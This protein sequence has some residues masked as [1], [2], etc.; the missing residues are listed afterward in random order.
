[1]SSNADYYVTFSFV[2]DEYE[3]AITDLYAEIWRINPIDGKVFSVETGEL[4]PRVF[5]LLC[6]RAVM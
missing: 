1:M 6:R 5:H 3:E 2:G 4:E